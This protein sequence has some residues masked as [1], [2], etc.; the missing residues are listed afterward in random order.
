LV[1]ENITMFVID[2]AD[3]LMTGSFERDVL[4]IHSMLPDTKQVMAFS[5]TYPPE[6][7]ERVNGFVKTPHKVQMC[8]QKYQRAES[9]EA[10][11]RTRG[12]RRRG[13][14]QTV[15]RKYYSLAGS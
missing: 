5:A 13:H 4:F 12:L 11:L 9:G 1:T 14:R 15:S 3:L 6:V 7:V 2:E 10:V 8:T